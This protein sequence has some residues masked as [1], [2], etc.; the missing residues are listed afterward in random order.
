MD[1][2]ENT[3]LLGQA[4]ALIGPRL[5]PG[6]WNARDIDARLDFMQDVPQSECFPP[7]DDDEHG[8]RAIDCAESGY[9]VYT[10]WGWR[11]ARTEQEAQALWRAEKPQLIA[12]RDAELAG[13]AKLSEVCRRL[14]AALCD[15]I[16]PGLLLDRET[17][18][19]IE[20]P[21]ERWWADPLARQLNFGWRLQL[22]EGDLPPHCVR[23]EWLGHDLHA[24]Q[25][26]FEG[27]SGYLLLPANVA[28]LVQGV[29]SFPSERQQPAAVRRPGRRKKM[30]DAELDALIVTAVERG[31]PADNW[32]SL[33]NRVVSG[34]ERPD[35]WAEA[36]AARERLDRAGQGLPTAG[37]L[38]RAVA[39]RVPILIE[40]NLLQ[41]APP[42]RMNKPN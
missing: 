14:R 29:S 28:D 41:P 37:S 13:R 26:A 31:A 9:R 15:G 10:R 32:S 33:A 7:Y 25:I 2:P 5:L 6:K 20:I 16:V 30:P 27:A 12:A 42:E 23:E 19:S 35:G 18:G 17:G 11:D 22:A 38:A 40:K 3:V 8:T 4:L 1:W 21:K 39:V 24:T 36:A 34:L